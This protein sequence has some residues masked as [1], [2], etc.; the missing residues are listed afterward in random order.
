MARPAR[1][2]RID[3]AFPCATCKKLQA[4]S[5]STILKMERSE[6]I[7]SKAKVLMTISIATLNN[8]MVVYS[9]KELLESGKTKSA[10]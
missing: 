9:S 5:R 6:W 7:K 4:S 2:N 10:T 3:R 8:S 1:T